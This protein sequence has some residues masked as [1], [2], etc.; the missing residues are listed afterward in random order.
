MEANLEGLITC[1]AGVVLHGETRMRYCNRLKKLIDLEL[2]EQSHRRF[3]P[4]SN[5]WVLVSP[6]RTQRPWQGHVDTV[7]RAQLPEYDPSCYLCPGNKRAGGV[8]NPQYEETFAFTND[9]PALIPTQTGA[10][11][12]L[13]ICRTNSRKSFPNWKTEK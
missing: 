2:K 4:L 6:H 9:Y 11:A 7:A 1:I 13:G 12:V 8:R 10:T 5:E 3:N